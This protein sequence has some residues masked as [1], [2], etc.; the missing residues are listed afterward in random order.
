MDEVAAAWAK[1]TSTAKMSVGNPDNDD[2]SLLLLF[3]HLK[4]KTLQTAK[5]TS[6][7]PAKLEFD[8]VLHNARVFC[9]MGMLTF[10]LL[11]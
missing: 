3:Q 1:S 2:P 10:N 9:R 7:V 8:F 4:A 5:G 11:S 6:E